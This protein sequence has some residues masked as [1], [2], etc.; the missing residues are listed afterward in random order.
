MPVLF[1]FCHFFLNTGYTNWHSGAPR[2]GSNKEMVLIVKPYSHV[3]MT[4]DAEQWAWK[5]ETD[6][7]WP[8][9]LCE[10]V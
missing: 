3:G 9:P 8:G 7:A 1:T 2:H 10:A 6:G 4:K 5:D